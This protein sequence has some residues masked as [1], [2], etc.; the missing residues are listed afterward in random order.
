MNSHVVAGV[1][2]VVFTASVQA[3]S[4]QAVRIDGP[5][6]RLDGR[7][8]E[9][10]WRAAPAITGFRQREPDE[11]APAPEATE[12]RLLY[13][14]DALY[15][16]ARM[17]SR[18]PKSIVAIVTR[19]DNETAAETFYVSVDTYHDRRTAYSFGVT[20]AGVRLDFYHPSDNMDD[21]DSDYDPVWEARAAIDSLGWTAEMRIPFGQLRFSRADVQ[22]WG[23]NV[24]RFV[25]A[26]N[27]ESFW[28][29]VP[30]R[31]TGWSS[32]MG[33][34]TGIRG[35][36]PSR[37]IEA[38]PYVAADSRIQQVED[39]SNPFLARTQSAA[40]FGGDLKMGLGPNLT[41]DVTV[42]PD[43]GQVEGDPAIVNLSAFE[44]FFD[45]RR[46][47]FLEGASLLN[48]RNLF[49]SRRIGAPPP[50]SAD[51]DYAEVKDNSTILGAAKL[52]GRLASGLSVAGL[53]AVTDQ[54]KVKT[55]DAA[56]STF[57][58]A[59][60]AP[61]VAYAAAAAQQE[62]GDDG[63][64][65]AAMLTAVHR[66]LASGSPLADVVAR[67]AFSGIVDARHRWAGGKYDVNFWSGHALV[68]G[69][70]LAILRQQRSSRRYWQRVDNF[71]VDSTRRAMTG[72]TFG[73]GH[74][75]LGG[76]HWLWDVDYTHEST[77]FEP[78]DLGRYG[79]VDNR[80]TF[81]GV[82]WRET[83]PS[84]RFRSYSISL[85]ANNDYSYS[86]LRRRSSIDAGWD[87]TLP[88]FWRVSTD[89]TYSARAFSDRLTRG[90]PVMGTAAGWD[91]SL[92]LQSRRGGRNEWGI[93]VGV[94]K[95]E[96]GSWGTGLELSLSV[97]PNDRL[98]LSLDPEWAKGRNMRQYLTTVPVTSNATYNN[99][100]VFAAVDLSEVS[101]RMRA[102]YTFTPNLTL[103]TYGEP[104]VSSGRF[105]TF[106][107]LTAPRARTLRVYGRD[108]GSIATNVEGDYTVTDAEGSFDIENEDFKV[109]S[110]RSNAVLRW[111]WRPG[112]TLFLVWQQNRETD[113]GGGVA[114][115]RDLFDTM[116]APGENF[117]AVK[118][119]Y[120]TALR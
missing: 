46:P 55:F 105:H 2:A 14:D 111:E 40:R 110:F 41:L 50:G 13:D 32:R 22:E 94:D 39:P 63:S 59:I 61:R 68:R 25:P 27:E 47:F 26:R 57:G 8:N 3:Q 10:A 67:D 51:A 100:Y 86:W 58:S 4:I 42:N 71:R 60:V 80:H 70:T 81:V 99:R 113:R 19:R 45:E 7:L 117:L 106:G 85:G 33:A 18:D 108:G 65:V 102:N 56:S 15:V 83:Q 38:L 66:D 96:D 104:F 17:F 76:K 16:G 89:A 91:A 30:K 72:G 5:S 73:V 88:N 12:V 6:P 62:F 82:R 52:T 35:I 116:G 109:L 118:L 9:P 103:E 95:N 114:G 21:T 20:P 29:L 120:W 77:G 34:L 97:R 107:Q 93:D 43:F 44:V 92:E 101:A 37:R 23:I 28:Q 48:R 54:E 24:A 112:S 87:F 75:K 115:P 31:E 53:A 69:D 36:R 119:T 84:K 79:T 98:E 64:T 74:S 11:G 78:N 49:Y 90:G 1:L